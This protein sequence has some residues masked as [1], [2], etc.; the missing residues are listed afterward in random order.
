LLTATEDPAGEAVDGRAARRDRNRT[1]VLDAV[2]GLFSEEDLEPAPEA[3]A[4]RSGVSL[5]SVYRYFDDREALLGA[6]VEHKVEQVRPLLLI[7]DFGHGTRLERIDR[8]VGARLRAYDEIASTHRAA[9]RLAVTSVVVRERQQRTRMALRHQVEVQL[10]PE[11]D[12]LRSRTPQQAE[13]VLEAADALLQFE[14][15]DLY[16][17]RRGLGGDHTHDLLVG[18]VTTLVSSA[19]TDPEDT[20]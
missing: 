9:R 6:A 11:L 20:T 4:E 10:A 17:L 12:D 8:L 3:V 1:A 15:L 5:R 18:A 16:R 7:H 2:V 14:T 13:V 19:T